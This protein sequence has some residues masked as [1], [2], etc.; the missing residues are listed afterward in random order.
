M[1]DLRSQQKRWIILL[2]VLMGIN[3]SI[4]IWFIGSMIHYDNINL[5]P[6]TKQRDI[7]IPAMTRFTVTTST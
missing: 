4:W 3:L 7:S 2:K 6:Q 5:S 1:S